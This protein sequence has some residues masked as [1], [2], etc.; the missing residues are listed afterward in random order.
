MSAPG[1][2]SLDDLLFEALQGHP[3]GISEHALLKHLQTNEH[4]ASLHCSFKDN[5]SL[6]RAHFLLFHTLYRLRDR[7]WADRAAHLEID[8]LCLRLHPY[9]GGQS[10]IG[11]HDALREYYLDLSNLEDT[12]RDDVDAMLQDF[13]SSLANTDRRA[14]ALAALELTDPVSDREIKRQ[15]RRLAMQHHPDRG[16]SK[17]RLQVLNAAMRIL[18]RA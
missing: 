8:T 5:H 16:G 2:D 15:Y 1:T 18:I 6:F 12:T 14:Q 17:E 9:S 11:P 3:Q 7:L 4:A 13:Y 10:E